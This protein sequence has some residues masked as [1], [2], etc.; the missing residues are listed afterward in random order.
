MKKGMAI[1]FVLIALVPLANSMSLKDL[2]AKYIFSAST[3]DMDVTSYNDYMADRNGNGIND[4]LVLELATSSTNGNF[5]FVANLLDKNGILTNET[6][7]TLSAGANKLN[8]TFDSFLL[9]QSQFN[10]SIK[11]YNSNYSLK[12][13]KDDILTKIYQN[14]E[15][16]FRILEIKDSRIGKT[17]RINITLNSS[18][19][20]PFESAL[21]MNYNNSIISAKNNFSAT[22][23][24]NYLVFDFGNET[25]KRTHYSGSFNVS[26]IKIGKKA[27]KT[28]FATG[29]YDFRDF[30]ASSYFSGFSDEGL[31]S[32]NNKY[33]FLRVNAE[34]QITD[35]KEYAVAL[36]LYDALDNLAEIKN[37][38]YQLTEGKHTVSF[39]FNGSR[40]RSKKL[41]GPFAVKYIRLF[42]NGKLIDEMNN[43][44]M[45]KNYNFN[46][47]ESAD[48]PDLV[49]DISV[50]GGHH[51][52]LNNI[53]VNFTFKNAGKKHAFGVFT[54]I[55]DNNTFSKSNKSSILNPGSQIIH[56][57]YFTNIS[58]VEF[59]ALADSGNIVEESDE[60]NN[61]QKLIIKIN[62]KPKL[63]S[64]DDIAAN[65]TDKITL[66]LSASD[67]NGDSI[68]FSVNSSKFIN[69]SNIFEWQTT[70][71]DSGNYTFEAIVSDGYLN[72]SAVFNVIVDDNPEKD[73]DNDGI[74]DSLD[75]LIGGISNVNTSTIN[76]S[77]FLND[78]D[79]L[80]KSLDDDVPVSILDGNSPIA[81]F[82]YNF[83]SD[84]LNLA[85]LTINKQAGNSTGYIV[86][87]G[88]SMPAGRTKTLY[89]DR[90]NPNVNGICI[91]DEE[92]SEISEISSGCSLN[93]EFRIECD[94]TLQNSYICSYNSTLSKYKVRGLK[95]SGI[96]QIDYRQPLP[97]GS[98]P[99]SSGSSGSG[100]SSSGSS[101][102]C[103]S[104]WEC[105]KWSVC[106]GGVSSR[107]CADSNQCYSP[108]DK[109]LELQQCI[110]DIKNMESSYGRSDLKNDNNQIAE[111]I[112]RLKR[113]GKLSGITG[114]AAASPTAKNL[115]FG[116]F[117]ILITIAIIG[118]YL[119]KKFNLISKIFK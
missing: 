100:I 107:K 8:I 25:I 71:L 22:G 117:I 79:N 18:A 115:H 91:K 46:D 75:K 63:N 70:T 99:P 28:D 110:A 68:T 111:D 82:D 27:I 67:E 95:H 102:V 60:D 104:K 52:G 85:N 81:E 10:Y 40:I 2:I 13:R 105:A 86:F 48:L 31:A 36:G 66:N 77:I 76:L 118:F 90:L 20:G 29:F 57:A 32:S 109:P 54:E 5:I 59:T 106:I 73:S 15:E 33:N 47:F 44:Y 17:L 55:F 96:I 58:D 30:A 49:A 34:M 113:S 53:T 43:A 24:T 12:Y 74:N 92:I 72:D 103:I 21:Y 37:M 80:S 1:F 41:N 3:S 62:K 14:Y 23:S 11:I 93:S 61:A 50:S 45:T 6:N 51:Y 83:S 98:S 42:D 9:S 35:A 116:I 16:G 119:N 89:L 94:G 38:S 69:K 26:S 78:S 114:A 64:L 88:L 97:G 56:Q 39:D 7:K 87:R 108:V 84:K 4:T 19:S 112:Q 101:M 65:E